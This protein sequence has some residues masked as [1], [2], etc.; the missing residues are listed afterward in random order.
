MSTIQVLIVDDERLSRKRLRRMLADDTS[1]EV[2]GEC[3]TG[4]AALEFLST[5]KVDLLFLDIEMPEMD[6]F[7]LLDALSAEEVPCTIFV[8][9]FD[10]FALRAFEVHAFDYLLKPYEEK[11]LLES[12][13]RAKAQLMARRPDT[14]RE[15]LQWV[16]ESLHKKNRFRDRIAVRSGENLLL[17]RTEQVDWI[18]AA[19]NYVYLH[20][21]QEKFLLRETMTSLQNTLDPAHFLRIHRSAIV[22]LDRV[23][24]LQP[25]FRGDYRVVLCTGAHLTL[26]RSYRQSLEERL[27]KL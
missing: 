5:R 10:Q 1:L 24:A 16:L 22:N 17:L 21:G 6:G 15:R 18:E 19:D 27:L 8:T 26:S 12:V 23:K 13:R 9:A 2:I 11:R 14:D 25:W 20:C 4:R 3:E 7:A